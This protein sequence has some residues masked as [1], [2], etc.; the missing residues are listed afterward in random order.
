ML[1][2]RQPIQ[3]W[4]NAFSVGVLE[5][6]S[7]SSSLE[8]TCLYSLGKMRLPR[9]GTGSSNPL[10]LLQASPWAEERAL[11]PGWTHAAI[12]S[13]VALSHSSSSFCGTA[14][15]YVPESAFGWRCTVPFQLFAWG[16]RLCG[17]TCLAAVRRSLLAAETRDAVVL[18]GVQCMG[19][20][21]VELPR[22]WKLCLVLIWEMWCGPRSRVFVSVV[23][24]VCGG[25]LYAAAKV[26][27]S[28]SSD[29]SHS[30]IA[31]FLFVF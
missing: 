26:S 15:C 31:C 8:T 4:Q 11:S 12:R 29:F 3:F 17:G 14:E 10:S 7:L 2:Y 27:I 25:C 23:W 5:W 30:R 13:D 28:P 20:W 24:R 19:L 22:C 6:E 21:P 16:N 1:P 18:C 9:A